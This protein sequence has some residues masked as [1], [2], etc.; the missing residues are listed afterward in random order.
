MSF[1]QAIFF[2]GEISISKKISDDE[3]HHPWPHTLSYKKGDLTTQLITR[4][5]IVFSWQEALHGSLE[6]HDHLLLVGACNHFL[7]F[8]FI[9]ITNQDL[10]ITQMLVRH[11]VGYKRIKYLLCQWLHTTNE[12]SPFNNKGVKID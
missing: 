3:P 4:K 11:E 9:K 5:N 7:F 10:F 1:N 2:F 12:D 6:G 8:K